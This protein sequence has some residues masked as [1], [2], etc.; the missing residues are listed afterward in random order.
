MKFYNMFF[1][2]RIASQLLTY[3]LKAKSVPICEAGDYKLI[4]FINCF[5]FKY[6]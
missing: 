6:E 2:G 1:L 3:L 5:Y 4:N